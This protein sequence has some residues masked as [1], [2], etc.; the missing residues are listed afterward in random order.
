MICKF[1][2][3]GNCKTQKTLMLDIP[4][5]K[6][7]RDVRQII[8]K[9]VARQYRNSLCRNEWCSTTWNGLY[10]SFIEGTYAT[11]LALMETSEILRYCTDKCTENKAYDILIYVKEN[12]EIDY[13][14]SYENLIRKGETDM[15]AFCEKKM[16]KPQ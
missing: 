15:Y 12:E 16:D 8:Y 9:L 14:Q 6:S 7:E 4:S 2:I 13:I 1:I 10:T 11:A 5:A 3:I